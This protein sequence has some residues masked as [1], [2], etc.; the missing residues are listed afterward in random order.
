MR[1]VVF[2]ILTFSLMLL[3]GTST[4][5]ASS[6]IDVDSSESDRG[7]V[8]VKFNTGSEKKIKLLVKHDDSKYYYNLSNSEDYVNFPLQFGN[9]TYTVSIYENTTGSK[10]RKLHSESFTVNV[11]DQND[12]FLNSI[13]EI[14]W[15]IEDEAIAMAQVLVDEATEAKVASTR[16]DY[17][18]LTDDEVIQLM[19]DYVVENIKYDYDKIK[20]LEYNYIPDINSTLETGTGICY[21]YSSLLASMLRSQGVPTK[22]V[23][24][25]TS[26]TSVY[27]AWNEIYLASEDR[28]VIVDTTYDS[29]MYLR[30]R[31]YTFE[32]SVDVYETKKEF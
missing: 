12:V 26:W 21:D 31:D 1:K 23:K 24:G 11:E 2:F 17:A 14:D 18:T 32:K 15:H 5:A 20:G 28:W 16:N 25:Y 6:T 9:G 22:L 19:Y 27:H 29:Y 10:Y 4:L 7:I 30:N 3:V 13:Q 8:K